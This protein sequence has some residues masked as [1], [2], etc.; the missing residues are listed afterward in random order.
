VTVNPGGNGFFAQPMMLRRSMVFGDYDIA[1]FKNLL[2][3]F[4]EADLQ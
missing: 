3:V 1:A 4:K 2:Q